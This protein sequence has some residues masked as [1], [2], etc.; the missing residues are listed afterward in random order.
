MQIKEAADTIKSNDYAH[1]PILIGIEG[2]SGAGKS[3]VATKLAQFLG[4]AYIIGIDDFIVKEKLTDSSWD[5]G[6]FDRARLERQI[7]IPSTNSQTLSYQKLLW[8]TSQLSEFIEIP[9]VDHLIIE[10]ISAYHPDIEKYYD[11]KIWVET[12]IDVANRRGRARDGSNENAQYWE[13]WSKNDLRYQQEHH[14]ELAADFI[15]SNVEETASR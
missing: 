9:P 10:G 8:Q 1:T 6:V 4:R 15:I 3:T 7:L 5:A 2:F 13:L 12:P 14:P 11:Y